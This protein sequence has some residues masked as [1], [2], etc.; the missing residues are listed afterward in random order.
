MPTKPAGPGEPPWRLRLM[1]ATGLAVVLIAAVLVRAA[2]DRN[3]ISRRRSVLLTV[4]ERLSEAQEDALAQDGRYA[5]HLAPVG[6]SDTARFVAPLGIT[7]A[8]ESLGPTAWRVVVSDS[9]LRVGPRSCGI[10]RGAADA[11][12]HRAV[13]SPGIP[14]CW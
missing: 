5:T 13:V 3:E 7:V 8:F 1:L 2:L 11:S 12:P 10:F 9:A 14:A 6:G 4:L